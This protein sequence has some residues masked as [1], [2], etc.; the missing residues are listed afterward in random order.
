VPHDCCSRKSIDGCLQAVDEFGTVP[1]VVSV[2][3][4]LS[5]SLAGQLLNELMACWS[6]LTA[7]V[8]DIDN[9]APC[10]LFECQWCGIRLPEDLAIVGFN[11]LKASAC[12]YPSLRSIVT[13]RCE[14]VRCAAA[15]IPEIIRGS[16]HRPKERRND[17]GFRLATP[18]STGEPPR[19][20]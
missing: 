6:A 1:M 8:C 19:H 18:K 2:D 13:P 15:I 17:L 16:A 10:A 11:D 12:A 20:A 7:T 5:M 14:M 9:P 3:Q 4:P